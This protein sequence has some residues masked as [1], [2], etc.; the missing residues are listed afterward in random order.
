MKL[1]FKLALILSLCL[2][3]L[4]ERNVGFQVDAIG[5][6][7]SSNDFSP[8][9]KISAGGSF[10]YMNFQSI[11]EIYQ[12]NST[13][14]WF[15]DFST[16]TNLNTL[17]WNFTIDLINGYTALLGSPCPCLNPQQGAEPFPVSRRDLGRQLR[18][19]PFENL[20]CAPVNFGY[21]RLVFQDVAAANNTDCAPADI[22]SCSSSCSQYCSN[23]TNP[24][25]CNTGCS[26]ITNG[27]VIDTNDC[28]SAC[29]INGTEDADCINGCMNIVDCFTEMSCRLDI[30]YHL[31]KYQ[32]ANSTV[33]PTA[34]RKLVF[35]FEILPQVSVNVSCGSEFINW[36]EGPFLLWINST[37]LSVQHQDN[38]VECL[39]DLNTAVMVNS[40]VFFAPG[41]TSVIGRFYVD[42]FTSGF[43]IFNQ[44]VEM[45][46]MMNMR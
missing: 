40:T 36:I 23:V 19:D 9:L 29:N 16:E 43:S 27:T 35:A 14:Q 42:P 37:T 38:C 5:V 10:Y 8:F 7:I 46:N 4:S 28:Y 32:W 44:P 18:D 1:L 39:P 41:N 13:N 31:H 3:V 25:N 22:S 20:I 6:G 12:D 26:A 15:K 21:F 24:T 34:P 45:A 11:Y 17:S 33:E 2:S 30:G